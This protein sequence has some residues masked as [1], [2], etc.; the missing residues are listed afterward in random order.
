MND[1]SSTKSLYN[2]ILVCISHVAPMAYVQVQ[3]T[4]ILV[5]DICSKY[6]SHKQQGDMDRILSLMSMFPPK[7]TM[8]KAIQRAGLNCP[9]LTYDLVTK[10]LSDS[11]V[12]DKGHIICT[13][14]GSQY[15]GS[16]LKAVVDAR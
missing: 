5:P 2:P 12:T 16:I 3:Y 13:R 10:F 14:H 4:P 8:L 1:S 6:H 11:L 15:I 7:P 9:R